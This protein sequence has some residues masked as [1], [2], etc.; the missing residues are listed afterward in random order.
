MTHFYTHL[1]TAEGLERDEI[2]TA[3]PSLEAA[4]LDACASIPKLAAELIAEGHDPSACSLEICDG[5]DLL[6]IEVPF[7]ER[8]RRAQKPSRPG[9]P[10]ISPETQVLLDQLDLLT[11]SIRDE[12][13][14]LRGNLAQAREEVASFQVRN[15]KPNW[16]L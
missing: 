12:T 2:G 14:K 11:L 1:R 8:V 13:A 15:R 5:A 4:Y 3:Y 6:L 7:L 16:L 9:P 10:A